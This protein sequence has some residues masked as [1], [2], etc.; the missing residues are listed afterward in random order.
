[1]SLVTR[2]AALAQVGDLDLTGYR[3]ADGRAGIRSSP[4]TSSG[5]AGPST[6]W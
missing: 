4:W 1:M 3:R 5:P 6:R 2:R